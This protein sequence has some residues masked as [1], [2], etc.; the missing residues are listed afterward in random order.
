MP[1]RASP[2]TLGPHAPPFAD[3]FS[4]GVFPGA[5]GRVCG[6]VLSALA[7]T[8]RCPLLHAAGWRGSSSKWRRV[9]A[10][11][12][13]G[14]GQAAP[15]LKV[16]GRPLCRL[17]STEPLCGWDVQMRRFHSGQAVWLRDFLEND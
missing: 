1:T 17:Q 14:A 2:P 15:P 4:S 6:H 3:L 5:V 9:R 7:G 13:G 11:A 12:G 10:G 8:W 16:S